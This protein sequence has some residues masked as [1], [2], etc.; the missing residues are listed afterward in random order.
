MHMHE[1]NCLNEC[2]HFR[3]A[4]VILPPSVVTQCRH[5]R[6]ESR[7]QEV[8]H[9][10]SLLCS[11]LSLSLSLSP[12]LSVS[13]SE[14][15]SLSL[16]LGVY[17]LKAVCDATSLQATASVVS[18]HSSQSMICLMCSCLLSLNVAVIVRS[19]PLFGVSV[20]D[21]IVASVSSLAVPTC[22]YFS[23]QILIVQACCH[24]CIQLINSLGSVHGHVASMTK[25]ATNNN[26]Q[27]RSFIWSLIA[28]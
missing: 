2:M 17:S 23:M 4:V 16:P 8:T 18:L 20:M 6:T 15:L 11:A 14:T 13:L 9:S 25:A 10:L 12:S 21:L 27:E 24:I 3:Y 28:N 19:S 7:I 22:M 1:T 26:K 5:T